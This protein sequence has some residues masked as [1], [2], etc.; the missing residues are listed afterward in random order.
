MTKLEQSIVNEYKFCV[1]R[2]QRGYQPNLKKLID[3]ILLNQFYSDI[4]KIELLES[5][6]LNY[7][8]NEY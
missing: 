1:D 8:Q 6:I 3:K 5:K 7:S 4:D 2:A